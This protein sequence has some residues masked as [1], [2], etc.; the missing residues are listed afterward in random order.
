MMRHA[1]RMPAF[2]GRGALGRVG[3]VSVTERVRCV[4]QCGIAGGIR[5]AQESRLAHGIASRAFVAGRGGGTHFSYGGRSW[6]AV[7][8][9][10]RAEQRADSVEAGG[11][12]GAPGETAYAE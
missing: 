6:P 5:T 1:N 8:V 7:H 2:A 12:A 4:R 9:L 10:S 11:A 3:P